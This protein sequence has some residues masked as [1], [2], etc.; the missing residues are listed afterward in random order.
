M[1]CR[2]IFLWK[3]MFFSNLAALVLS[4]AAFVPV[5]IVER[6]KAFGASVCLIS[7]AVQVV[8]VLVVIFATE[9]MLKKRFDK[10]GDPKQ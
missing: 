8:V 4:I 5:L 3:A 6:F 2:A 1:G 9:G 7:T 10:N